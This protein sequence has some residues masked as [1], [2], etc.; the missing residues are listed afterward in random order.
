MAMR[1]AIRLRVT[2]WVEGEDE[3][4][5]DF[6]ASTSRAVCDIIRA[7]RSRYP[8]LRVTVKRVT[9]AEDDDDGDEDLLGEDAS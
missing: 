1:K 5:H 4:A 2:L 8:E 7:G 6:Y 3:P 9:E